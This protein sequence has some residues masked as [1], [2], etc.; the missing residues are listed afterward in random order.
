[1]NEVKER[2]VNEETKAISE[3]LGD[4][5]D[6]MDP[7]TRT[8]FV[9]LFNQLLEEQARTIINETVSEE[10]ESVEKEMKTRALQGVA[11]LGLIGVMN[12]V[13]WD[14]IKSAQRLA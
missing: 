12:R 9:D 3:L 5:I 10:P 8:K 14:Q 11:A 1:M 13:N 6:Q 2:T 4:L 7:E